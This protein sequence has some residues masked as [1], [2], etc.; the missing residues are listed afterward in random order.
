MRLRRCL[1]VPAVAAVLAFPAAHAADITQT[2]DGVTL[3][4]QDPSGS[5]KA[6]VRDRIIATFFSAYPRERADFHPAAPSSV[7]IVMDPSYDGVAYVGEKEKAATITINPRWL[8]KHPNDTD[9]VTHE[10][11]HIVQGYP[12]YASEQ[13]PSWLV[14][15]IADYA[16][17]VYGVDNA[18]GGWAL[19]AQ[20][21]AEHKVDTGYRVTGA[22]LKWS[23]A[24]HPGLVEALDGA[25]R[26]GIYTPAL[27]KQRTGNDLAALWEAYVAQRNGGRQA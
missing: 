22:F 24:E 1:I 16:R 14:E 13:A 7:R 26:K 23:E 6:D 12:G 2:R 25:L 15:G 11:M 4:Y 17:D 19:P 18:A 9:L 21:K 20:V 5:T 3:T 8:E 27:W 10:A